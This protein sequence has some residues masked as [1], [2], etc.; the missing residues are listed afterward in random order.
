MDRL[1]FFLSP[2][3]LWISTFERAVKAVS[4]PEKKEEHAIKKAKPKI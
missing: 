4:E 3:I 2:L 1:L